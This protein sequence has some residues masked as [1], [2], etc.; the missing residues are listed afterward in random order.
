MEPNTQNSSGM[1]NGIPPVPKS[2]KKVGPII[3]ALVVVL[4]IIIAVL[5][6]F[7]QKLNTTSDE[8]SGQQNVIRNEAGLSTST[9]EVDLEADLDAQL[10]DIDYSF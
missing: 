9:N 3:G 6:F 8:N 4:I 1:M 7:G 10:Q 2:D 5:W